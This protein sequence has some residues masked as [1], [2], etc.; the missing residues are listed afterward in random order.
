MLSEHFKGDCRAD[1]R[2]RTVAIYGTPLVAVI[3]MILVPGF[4]AAIAAARIRSV[5]PSLVLGLIKRI[6]T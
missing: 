2:F 1:R 3:A 4:A 5:T 6:F